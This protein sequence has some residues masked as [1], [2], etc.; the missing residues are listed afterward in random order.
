MII[1]RCRKE[2]MVWISLMTGDLLECITQNY[3]WGYKFD[4]SVAQSL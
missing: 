3:E 2:T 4:D 1:L